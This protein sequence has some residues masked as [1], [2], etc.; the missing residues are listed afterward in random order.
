MEFANDYL[1]SGGNISTINQK[2]YDSATF[3]AS[4]PVMKDLLFV[5]SNWSSPSYDLWEEEESDHF[6]TR[7]VQRRAL[8]S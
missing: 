4:A 7:M 6:Y 2:I 1:A 3:P 5:A 8:V